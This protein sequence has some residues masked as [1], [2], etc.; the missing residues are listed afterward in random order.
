MDPEI[1]GGDGIGRRRVLYAAGVAAAATL[2]GC[3]DTG[4]DGNGDGGTETGGTE[5]ETGDAGG[6]ETASGT[7]TADSTETDDGTE[8][9]DNTETD[10][11]TETADSTETDGGAIS[12]EIRLGGETAGWTG[13]APASIEGETNPTLRLEA[14]TEYT[15]VWENLDGVDH[16]LVIV[17]NS[18]DDL[19]KSDSAE[20][21][22]ETV[23]TTFTAT[24]E[25]AEYYCEYHPD[26][27]RGE[28]VV[29]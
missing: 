13:I 29:E 20:E 17:D 26:S 18:D 12:G 3:N 4:G 28:I 27:M 6:T 10:G 11:G 8:T 14:D 24:S 5:N 16:E 7:E 25:M 21:E 22:G 19:V 2:A 23:T 1:D 15:V 9:A